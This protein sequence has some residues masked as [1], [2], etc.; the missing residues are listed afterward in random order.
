MRKAS[1]FPTWSDINRAVQPQKM[2]SGMKFWIK[3][4]E[5]L[6]YLCRE[7]KG[8]DQHRGYCTADLRLCFRI[9]KLLVFS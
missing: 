4:V 6:N 8:A 5:G 2:S 3:E 7:H 1:G 9:G